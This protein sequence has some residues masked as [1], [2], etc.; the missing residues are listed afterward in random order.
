MSILVVD[1]IA[2]NRMLLERILARVGLTDVVSLTSAREA[3]DYLALG[4]A[5]AGPCPVELILMDIMMPEVSGLEACRQIRADPRLRE[6]PIL[7]V[8]ARADTSDLRVAFEAGA[9]DFITKPVDRVILTARVQHQLRLKRAVDERIQREAQLLETQALLEEANRRLA[10]LAATDPLTGV[11]NRRAFAEALDREWLRAQRLGRPLGVVLLDI[12]HFK[13]YN[14]RHGHP[15]G[16]LCLQQVAQALQD[17]LRTG[18]DLVARYGGEEFAIVLPETDAAGATLAAERL[19]STIEGLGIEHG[20]SSA[21]P[22]VT[23]SVGVAAAAVS[24]E[25]PSSAWIAAADAALYEAK[26]AGRNCVR[27]GCPAA[28]DVPRR[29]SVG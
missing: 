28:G 6:I 16:D 19:R 21:G 14:D 8:T 5:D 29:N 1:D 7:M 15:A 24:P 27:S 10:E 2:D 20:N 11:A 25:I 13:G 18:V 22:C 26:A 17:A 9:S 4:R 3:F 12:D 23:V